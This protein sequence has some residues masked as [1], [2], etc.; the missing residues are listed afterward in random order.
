MLVSHP[1]IHK[2]SHV[3]HAKWLVAIEKK[4][5]SLHK[6]SYLGVCGSA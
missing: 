5:E 3:D 2:L 1:H 6:K 4:H